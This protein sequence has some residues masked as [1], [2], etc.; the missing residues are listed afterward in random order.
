MLTAKWIDRDFI[1][2]YKQIA[3]T[4]FDQK[5]D[6]L[7]IEAQFLD[8]KPLLGERLYDDINSNTSNYTFLFEGGTYDYE[9]QSYVNEGLKVVTV[10]YFYSRYSFYGS[11]TDTPFGS[12]LKL[13][14][15]KSQ[16]LSTEM[17]KSAYKKNKDFAFNVWRSVENYLIRTENPL[18]KNGCTNKRQNIK[19]SVISNDNNKQHRRGYLRDRRY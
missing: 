19:F 10:F 17:K 9:G 15:D 3:K 4:G 6:E 18:F 14:G 1:Q 11:N 7:I 12:V 13:N 16:P 2:Q 8:L 5:I